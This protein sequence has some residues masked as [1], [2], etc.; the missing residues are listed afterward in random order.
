MVAEA[1]DPHVDLAQPIE[2]QQAGHH[3]RVLELPLH[4]LER[5]QRAHVEQPAAGGVRS[6]SVRRSS[7]GSGGDRCSGARMS[8]DDRHELVVP[9][10]EC[11][12]IA[13]A[14]LRDRGDGP[15]DVRPPFERPAVPGEQRDVEL[16]L[17][18]ARAV[19]FE[20]EIRVPRHRRDGALEER[21]RVVQEAGLPRVFDRGEAAAGDRR[22]I[23]GQHRSPARPR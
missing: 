9:A 6:S 23:D 5:R 17:D 19:A 8:C 14:E 18:V 13:A 22:P 15:F 11:V 3:R 2:E 21:V 1:A 7:G 20:I 4:E 16:W 12:G 10:A